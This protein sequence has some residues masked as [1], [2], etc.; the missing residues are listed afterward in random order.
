MALSLIYLSLIGYVWVV[1]IVFSPIKRC[2]CY[3]FI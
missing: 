2:I 3:C 1:L